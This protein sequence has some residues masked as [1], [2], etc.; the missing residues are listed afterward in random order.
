MHYIS[1]TT[2]IYIVYSYAQKLNFELFSKDHNKFYP[3]GQIR[4]QGSIK[5]MIMYLNIVEMGQFNLLSMVKSI[6]HICAYLFI[7]S[8]S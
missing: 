8:I 3:N 4:R 1:K 7:A 6:C 2:E 5:L